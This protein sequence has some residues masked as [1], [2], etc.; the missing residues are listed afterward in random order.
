MALKDNSN[1]WRCLITGCNP[2]LIGEDEANNHALVE[3]H[4][5]AKW[6]QRSAIGQKK[7]DERNKNGY[8]DK[9]NATKFRNTKRTNKYRSR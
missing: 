6:P 2:Y 4:R 7:A 8:Y 3:G 1:R 5:V 9:Y